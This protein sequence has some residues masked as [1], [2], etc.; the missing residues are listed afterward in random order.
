MGIVEKIKDIEE[1]M[2]RTQKNK[3]TE[4]HLGLLKGK[5]ARYRQQ[6]LAD[7]GPGG[8]GGGPGSGFEVAKSGD[9]RV[10]LIGYPSVGKSSLLGKITSTRSE[11]AQYSFTTLTSVPGVLKYGGAEIQ[12]V[13]L[14]G[15]IY[16]AAQGKGRGRQVVSTARTA[17]LVLMVLDATKSEHQRQSL[18]HELESMG[19]RLNKT[20]PDIFFKRR[21]TGGVKVTFANGQQSGSAPA[22]SLDEDTVRAILRDYRVHNAEVLVRDEH[23]TVDDFIDIVNEPYCQYMPCL[24][25]YNKIDAVS[26]EE[27]SKLAREPNTTVMS[28]EL[29]LGIQDVVEEIWYQLNLSR[30]Y[31]KKRGAHPKFDDPLVVRSGATVA[32]LCQQVHRDFRDKFKYALVWGSSA[33]HS[34]QKCGLQHRIDDEDVVTLFTK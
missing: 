2:A 10:V 27:V 31:T 26:L 19:I 4:R 13:D 32:D 6:L 3:A 9:A 30:V 15:I 16:G 33:K 29:D 5:L 21:E 34:P 12:V 18:E 23:A 11:V 7:D 20:R 17:D 22:G 24:Y 8:G 1:E 14:P 25:V 28:C